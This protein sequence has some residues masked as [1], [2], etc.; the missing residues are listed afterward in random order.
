MKYI[1]VFMLLTA[2]AVETFS[3]DNSMPVKYLTKK[4]V[5]KSNGNTDEGQYMFVTKARDSLFFTT[6]EY[7]DLG[8]IPYSE[9]FLPD[10]VS[11]E[12]NTTI[13]KLITYDGK[14]Y[15][16]VFTAL[17]RNGITEEVKVSVGNKMI[18][19]VSSKKSYHCTNHNPVVHACP[20]APGIAN[21]P[22]NKDC[23]WEL[24]N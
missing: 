21:P 9:S 17:N 20:T 15:N 7:L 10:S 8:G 1:I 14:K 4:S 6:G 16:T 13:K 3:Q 11:T 22:C 5:F 2:F 12:S 24:D 18:L 19:S 23:I